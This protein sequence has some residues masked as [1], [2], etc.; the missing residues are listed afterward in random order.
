MNK[1]FKIIVNSSGLWFHVI[2]IFDR[3]Y[4]TPYSKI[5]SIKKLKFQRHAAFEG[6][7]QSL[8][9]GKKKPFYKIYGIYDFY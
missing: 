2:K 6:I 7:M 9:T 4:P 1:S 8:I 3:K 5:N